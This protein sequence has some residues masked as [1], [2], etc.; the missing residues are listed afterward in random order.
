MFNPILISSTGNLL[1]TLYSSIQNF[2]LASRTNLHFVLTLSF[3]KAT[4]SLW[5]WPGNLK[6]TPTGLV[7]SLWQGWVAVPMCSLNLSLNCL[8]LH[9]IYWGP[10]TYTHLPEP[11]LQ[12]RLYTTQGVMQDKL[13]VIGKLTPEELQV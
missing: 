6:W 9:P 12:V 10:P 11:L 8:S 13:D 5:W 7:V 2:S 3:G 4:K 1:I